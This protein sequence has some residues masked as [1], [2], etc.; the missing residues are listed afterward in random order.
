[1]LEKFRINCEGLLGEFQQW[2][3]VFLSNLSMISVPYFEKRSDILSMQEEIVSIL[4]E[5]NKEFFI[6]IAKS[7]L[8]YS[9]PD[10]GF[11][12]PMLV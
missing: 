3:Y 10:G 8:L 9:L 4:G 11:H 6:D 5:L 1:V 12:S 7:P 2:D